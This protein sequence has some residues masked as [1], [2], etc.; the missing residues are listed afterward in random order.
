MRLLYFIAAFLVLCFTAAARAEQSQL[1]DRLDLAVETYNDAR[2]KAIETVEKLIRD[3][4]DT[5]RGKGDLDTKKS[6]DAALETLLQGDLPSLKVLQGAV[7]AAERE[8]DRARSRLLLEFQQVEREYVRKG[9]DASA[10]EVRAESLE[11]NQRLVGAVATR[12]ERRKPKPGVP[13]GKQEIFL[14]D[15]PE[16]NVDAHHFGK[17]GELGFPEASTE[18]RIVVRGAFAQKGISTTPVGNGRCSVTYDVPPG[19]LVFKAIAAM[20]DSADPGIQVT[21]CTFKVLTGD[22][23]LWIS[24]PLRGRGAVA[25]CNIQLKGCRSVA[26]IVE[27][28]G[29]HNC[30]HAV[31]IDPRFLQK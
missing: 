29:I 15:L 26:L 12:A 19:S 31:W 10:E 8:L 16:Q 24:P 1:Q 28:P 25:E 2:D 6:L 30:A 11:V 20:N 14:S 22:K 4:I 7:R 27:C 23:V 21:P 17:N 3:R 5:A 13:D 18:S 9:D